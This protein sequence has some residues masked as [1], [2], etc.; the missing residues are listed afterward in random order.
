MELF[1]ALAVLAEPPA[2]ET[3]RLAEALGL[4]RPPAADE[5]TELFLFQ[6]Y[7]YASVYLGAEGM[8]GG[9]ARD[10]VGGFWRA[11]GEMPPAEPDHLS[12]MLALHAR[13]IELEDA[14]GDESR[15]E[16]WRRAR[17]AHL[18]EHLLSWLPA[19][20][21]KLALLAP[22]FYRRWA[23]ILTE[24]LLEEAKAVGCQESL[25]LHLRGSPALID[26]RAAEE[27][28][29]GAF[30][31]SILTPARSGLILTR[32]DL[33]KA[34]RKLGMG[35]RMGERKFILKALFA[36]DATAVFDWLIEEAALW[37]G[38][39]REHREA[40]GRISH[41]WEERSKA[42]SALLEELRAE[43]REVV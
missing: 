10:A 22:P 33:T 19:Y 15:R 18:W 41:V 30:C 5:Y 7:P 34:G 29:V 17:K 4:G 40:L 37:T 14:E 39:H 20:L 12:V 25:S 3:A 1:R 16:G 13:L 24:S 42:A 2:E 23:E 43:A 6:L 9:E 36:Q 31:Q 28:G 35:L 38:R 21:S 32:A 26:P 27:E 8:M 11:L